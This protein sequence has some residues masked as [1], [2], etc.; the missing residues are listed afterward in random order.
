MAPNIV[1]HAVRLF[2]HTDYSDRAAVNHLRR[3]YIAA[4][5]YLGDRWVLARRIGRRINSDA[6]VLVVTVVG[7]APILLHDI[8]MKV[9]G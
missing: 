8:V 6:G 2:P 5:N 9:A 3:S 4:R 1:R 7:A